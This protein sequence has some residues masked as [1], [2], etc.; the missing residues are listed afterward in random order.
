[1]GDLNIRVTG[2]EGL[3][4][5]AKVTGDPC[6]PKLNADLQISVQGGDRTAPVVKMKERQGTAGQYDVG[7]IAGTIPVLGAGGKL[8]A[9]MIP[10]DGNAVTEATVVAMIAEASNA[11]NINA[12]AFAVAL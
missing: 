11:S 1:M 6:D 2:K 12:L 9:S 8:P 4:R 3:L 5:I 10:I 7:T